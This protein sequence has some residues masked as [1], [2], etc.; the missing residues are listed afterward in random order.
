MFARSGSLRGVISST[1]FL[2]DRTRLLID[3]CGPHPVVVE[4]SDERVF[5]VGE[6]V[7]LAIRP[8]A[9]MALGGD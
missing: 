9:V 7:A 1:A 4:T 3:M 2:G 8:N 5:T 6:A